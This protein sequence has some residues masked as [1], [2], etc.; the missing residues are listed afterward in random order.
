MCSQFSCCADCKDEIGCD[1]NEISCLKKN[2][3]G[4]CYEF[5]RNISEVMIFLFLCLHF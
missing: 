1:H 4:Y 3:Y 2:Y 5:I